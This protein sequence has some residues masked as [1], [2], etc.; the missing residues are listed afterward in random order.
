MIGI[1]QG[2]LQDASLLSCDGATFLCQLKLLSELMA[3][4]RKRIDSEG[5]SANTRGHR[6]DREVQ[7][8]PSMYVL[9]PPHPTLTLSKR[10]Q[11]AGPSTNTRERR[12]VKVESDD[13]LLDDARGIN[14]KS[15]PEPTT[16][17]V[18]PVKQRI[19]KHE[20]R[21]PPPIVIQEVKDEGDSFVS[22]RVRRRSRAPVSDSEAAED[23]ALDE[24]NENL[25]TPTRRVARRPDI[26]T[27]RESDSG[28]PVP[29]RRLCRKS[30]SDDEQAGD[31]VEST[32]DSNDLALSPPP[33]HSK[34]TAKELKMKVFEEYKIARTH[35]ASPS[36]VRKTVI[37]PSSSSSEA[38]D[39]DALEIT[40][41]TDVESE[42]TGG[43]FIDDADETADAAQEVEDV[44][45]PERFARRSPREHFAV[46]IEYVV[47]LH[48]VP[49]LLSSD[50]LTEMDRMSYEA[51][52][53]ALRMRT[54]ALA[55]SM[56]IST[57]SGPFKYTLEKR[58][59]L[60]G[61]VLCQGVECQACWARGSSSC[62]HAGF[63]SLSTRKGYYNPDTF[64]D[65][66]ERYQEYGKETIPNF[67]N[68]AEADQVLYPPGFRLIIGARCT[69]RAV[70]YHQA[71]H[72]L[73]NTAV[74]VKDEIER[75]CDLHSRFEKNPNA[76]VEELSGDFA[77]ELLR[78]FEMDSSQWNNYKPRA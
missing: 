6:L 8:T 66:L 51:T 40:S 34:P 53:N 58:P 33:S 31:E 26:N 22:P 59:V 28:S 19:V 60:M 52:L 50:T 12:P 7:S 68:G 70:A 48:C 4:K 29:R 49:D 32:A 16:N 1:V 37:Q 56:L 5:S 3:P 77:A 36:A 76:L 2:R 17:H 24:E 11:N 62:S 10:R 54:E 71:R 57:W 18:R 21:S 30:D 67:E 38:E 41:G 14:I 45:G 74:R 13:E 20:P 73:Y 42:T 72:Y 9:V 44:I 65:I 35:K 78:D 69:R 55:D 27:E 47:G 64:E 15:E 75:V 23:I 61:P 43:S 63:Y 25:R 39:S 46:F